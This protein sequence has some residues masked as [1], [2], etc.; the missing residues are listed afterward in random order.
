M[1]SHTMPWEATRSHHLEE[2]EDGAVRDGEVAEEGGGDHEGAHLRWREQVGDGG[3]W[4]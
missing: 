4:R 2:E 3:R 1:R